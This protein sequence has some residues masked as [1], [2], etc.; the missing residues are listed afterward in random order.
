LAL[1]CEPSHLIICGVDGISKNRETDPQNYF[2]THH[3][4]ADS[5][6]YEDYKNSFEK[7]G[8]NLYRLGI[9]LNVIVKNLGIGKPYNMISNISKMF[10][11]D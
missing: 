3:G 4:T 2:R 10:E 11:N 8:T 5:Y 6:P 1:S 9:Q 7:F